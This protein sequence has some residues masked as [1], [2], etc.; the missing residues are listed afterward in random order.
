MQQNSSLSAKHAT[1]ESVAAAEHALSDAETVHHAQ[2]QVKEDTIEE[3]KRE[4]REALAVGDGAMNSALC[5]LRQHNSLL[6]IARL[7]PELLRAIF[8]FCSEVDWIGYRPKFHAGWLTVTH[9]C[10]RWRDVALGHSGLWA[11]NISSSLGPTWTDAFVQRAQ[12]VP[13]TLHVYGPLEDWRLRFLANNMPRTAC[14]KVD[15]PAKHHPGAFST[16]APLLTTLKMDVTDTATHMD[17]EVLSDNFLGGHAPMLR[18]LYITSNCVAMPWMTLSIFASI[19]SLHLF[20]IYEPGVHSFD[21]FL[22]DLLD[23]VEGM[24][25]LERLKISRAKNF[26][27]SKA[28]EPVANQQHRRVT[29][30][31]MVSLELDLI[32]LPD[33]IMLI[34]HLS[35]PHAAVCY[36][37]NSSKENEHLMDLFFPLILASLHCHADSAAQSFNAITSLD[38][39]SVKLGP[40]KPVITARTDAHTHEPTLT[41]RFFD[42]AWPA[43]VALTAL[44]SA[45]LRELTVDSDMLKHCPW[46]D[47][48]ALRRLVVKNVDMRIWPNRK[49][50]AQDAAMNQLLRTLATRAEAGF[51]LEELDVT[52]C[53][54]DA[55]WMERAQEIVG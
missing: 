24:R 29:L 7:A 20:S 4:V 53:D 1:L 51:P 55:A 27:A 46:P 23:G 43:R 39:G 42:K 54:V 14:L 5:A 2:L 17:R 34:S 33:T 13:L 50:E 35:M 45:H 44:A 19:T 36:Y 49:R 3:A 38:I 48:P 52:E 40:R 30:V 37:P 12:K 26:F 22:D 21:Q 10:E 18:K 28:E 31:K 47:M 25:E 16:D 41:V 11:A 32:S 9:V 8:T 15:F 6:P